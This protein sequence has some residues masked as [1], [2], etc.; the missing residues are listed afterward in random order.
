MGYHAYSGICT[1][2]YEWS[3]CGGV[4][5]QCPPGSFYQDEVAALSCKKCRKGQFVPPELSPGKSPLDCLTCP[6]G[7]D[8]NSSA[9][10]RACKCPYGF[11]RTYRFGECRRCTEKGFECIKDYPQLKKGFWMTWNISSNGSL[12]KQA[13]KA[14]MMNMETQNRSYD[15]NTM[16]Y[17]NHLPVP[18]KCPIPESCLGGVD[19]K[20]SKGYTGVLCAVCDQ[21]YSR[22]FDRC[23][24]C[25]KPFV[26][27][28]QFVGYIAL[29]V[30]VCLLITWAD[31]V[32]FSKSG[33]SDNLWQKEIEHRTLADVILSNLKILL[34]FYQVLNGVIHAFSYIHW[35]ENLKRAAG[36]FEYLEFEVLRIPSLRCIK[37]E[38]EMN[39]FREFWFV[40]IATISLPIFALLYFFI[41]KAILYS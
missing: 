17:T 8:T 19:A 12:S 21:G 35:P 24:K 11:A 23:I 16:K 37:P 22:Q 4:C 41:K 9:N 25:P 14:F 18:Y 1:A 32:S 7:T 28:L 2:D 33:S 38:W 13:F 26:A 20:C 10:Y 40:L 36:A 39:S 31:K 5:F 27:V 6:S 29:F 15:R 34:G 3:S 30:F